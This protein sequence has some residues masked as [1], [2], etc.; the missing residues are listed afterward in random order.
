MCGIVGY[1]GTKDACP[2]LIG[3]LRR[4]EYRGYDSAGI[5]TL[6]SND[7]F[8][9]TKVAGRVSQLEN[10][11]A[12]RSMLRLWALVI[13]VGQRMVQ[14]QKRTHIRIRAVTVSLRSHTMV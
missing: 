10:A 6:R 12:Q 7:S 5:A 11:V 2:F 8:R 3:G 9:V 1:V 14:Q 13:R 4:L